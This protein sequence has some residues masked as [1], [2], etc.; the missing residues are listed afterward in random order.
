M[1][2]KEPKT[3]DKQLE[4]LK[5]RNLKISNE[6]LAKKILSVENYYA[7]INGYKELFLKSFNPEIFQDDIYFENI[8]SLFDFDRELR[9]ILLKYILIVERVIKTKISYHFSLKYSDDYL[10]INNFDVKDNKKNL[11]IPG[12]INKMKKTIRIYSDKKNTN[13]PINHYKNKYKIIPLWVL[14]EKLNF[15][16]IAH[17]FYCLKVEDQNT[18]AREIYTDYVE[19]YNYTKKSV[20][21]PAETSEILFFICDFRNKCAHD[22]RIFSHRHK[23]ASRN[24]PCPFIFIEERLSFNN[25]VFALI[26]SLKIFLSKNNFEKMTKEIDKLMDNLKIL[27][28]NHSEKILKKMGIPKRWKDII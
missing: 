28:P 7:L 10:Q 21:N 16:V 6:K 26:M 8:F 22:E 27:L 18:I 19:E 12:L 4:I 11:K 13:T 20:L 24:S 3:Y 25:G 14:V 15:G 2:N 1:S 17:F 23:F 5:N 9:M